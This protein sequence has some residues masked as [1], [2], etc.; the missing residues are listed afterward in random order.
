MLLAGRLWGVGEGLWAGALPVC[1]L[2]AACVQ[3]VERAV[4][5]SWV[6]WSSKN[7]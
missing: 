2:Y 7:P 3:P 1:C 4:A 5:I 6:H